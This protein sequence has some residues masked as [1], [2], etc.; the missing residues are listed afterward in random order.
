MCNYFNHTLWN[1]NFSPIFVIP[2]ISYFNHTLWNWNR[3]SWASKGLI[4]TTLIIP[5]GIEILKVL[6]SLHYPKNFNHT[7][8][9]WNSV[10]L[11]TCRACL[12]FNHTLWN[13]NSQYVILYV[14]T[15]LDFNHTLWNWNEVKKE[16]VAKIWYTLIIPL[17]NWN[18]GYNRFINLDLGTLII[19]Y[20]IEINLE[21]K[22]ELLRINYI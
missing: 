5:Y 12:D 6:F 1:W 22:D 11:T 2:K 3:S 13:W 15:F 18:H 16:K 8:W 17:W 21:L 9:N 20:G 14:N 19:P 4:V 7:L 10:L